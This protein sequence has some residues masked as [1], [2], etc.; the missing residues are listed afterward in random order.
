[1]VAS[2]SAAGAAVA[3]AAAAGAGKTVHPIFLFIYFG[4]FDANFANNLNNMLC[5]IA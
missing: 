2:A 5:S 1:V 3:V 4:G